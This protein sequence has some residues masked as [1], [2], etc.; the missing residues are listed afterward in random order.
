MNKDITQGKWRQLRG[1]V[2]QP[3]VY[4]LTQQTLQEALEAGLE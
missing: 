1:A 4:S 2:K 3:W